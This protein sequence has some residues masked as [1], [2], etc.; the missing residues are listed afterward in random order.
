V[1]RPASTNTGQWPAPFGNIEPTSARSSQM[2][3]TRHNRPMNVS[4]QGAN[5]TS[6]QRLARWRGRVSREHALSVKRKTTRARHT[7]AVQKSNERR[8]D[9]EKMYRGRTW[10]T[11]FVT[12]DAHCRQL[13][14]FWTA[15]NVHL[16]PIGPSLRPY[17][18]PS[19][20]DRCEKSAD[21]RRKALID[22]WDRLAV[23]NCCCYTG[24]Y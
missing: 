15:R 8:S 10:C 20:P 11:D 24:P 14:S 13:S 19:R 21:D 4:Q 6:A 23:R 7:R 17:I 22:G 9:V 18:E 2:P 16:T 12:L 5:P 3:S 1:I